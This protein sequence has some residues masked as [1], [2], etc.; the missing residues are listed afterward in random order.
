M[1]ANPVVVSLTFDDQY[2]N[3][4]TYLRPILLAHD[5]HATFYVITSDTSAGYS[6]FMSYAQLRTLQAEGNDIGG[7][8]VYHLNLTDPSTSQQEKI[9]DVCGSR[10]DLLDNGLL[11][12]QSFAFPFG[13]F[14]A[15]AESIVRS[16]GFLSS[17]IAGGISS[18]VT[19]PEP[20]GS[21]RSRR[22]TPSP[23]GPSTSTA[24][25]T[26]SWPT[27]RAS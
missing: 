12:P 8:G 11:D 26:R 25:P 17:R 15:G 24:T 2:L 27:C 9:D 19:T 13:A 10:Q 18:S 14:D 3:H 23:S 6:G 22:A 7:H 21:R 16:C 1:K 20:P 4:W 5:M